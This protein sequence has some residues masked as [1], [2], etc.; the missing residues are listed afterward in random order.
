LKQCRERNEDSLIMISGKGKEEKLLASERDLKLRRT[1]TEDLEM[2]QIDEK[3]E[4][5][6]TR[7]DISE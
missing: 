2:E 1:L 3:I 4:N 5:R 6:E 7:N